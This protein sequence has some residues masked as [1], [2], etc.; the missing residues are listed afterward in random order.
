M[1]ALPNQMPEAG[2]SR[3]FVPW[4]ACPL[5]ANCQTFSIPIR[6]YEGCH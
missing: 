6:S 5:K 1:R 3:R 2:H 4:Q